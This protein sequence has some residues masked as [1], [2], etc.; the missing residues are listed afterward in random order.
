MHWRDRSWN[1]LVSIMLA[2]GCGGAGPQP[3]APKT[4]LPT[5][6][7]PAT[8]GGPTQE[9]APAPDTAEAAN[10][11]GKTLLFA[12]R[13]AE[14]TVEFERAYKLDPANV[15]FS[16]NLSTSLYQEGKYGQALPIAR[17]AFEMQGATIKQKRVLAKLAGAITEQCAKQNLE[18]SI[19]DDAEIARRDA[20]GQELLNNK[21]SEDA[22]LVFLSSYAFSGK[23]WPLL[24][25]A[26]LEYL[27]KDYRNALEH[28]ESA[29]ERLQ[30]TPKLFKEADALVKAVEKECADQKIRCR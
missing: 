2:A 13:Y 25:V 30:T 22:E 11:R 8:G 16:V 1:V 29:R 20:R 5:S 18:C 23:P 6:P 17:H 4:P 26:T 12:G 21:Q 27:M 14:A 9:S 24:R 7:Q 19:L 28:A 3:T 15:K 10:E